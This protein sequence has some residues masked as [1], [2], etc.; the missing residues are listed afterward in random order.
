MEE[1][2]HP[3]IKYI[4]TPHIGTVI[5]QGLAAVY[6]EKPDFPV[7]YLAKWLLNYCNNKDREEK[8]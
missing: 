8:L 7:D 1:E 3:D 2:L 6:M 5:S 4:K